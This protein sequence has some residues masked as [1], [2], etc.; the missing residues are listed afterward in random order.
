MIAFFD[1][2]VSSV[3][4]KLRQS[5]HVP[6]Y[7]ANQA[8]H[9]MTRFQ[10]HAFVF[11]LC[12]LATG[13]AEAQPQAQ[14]TTV[15]LNVNGAYQTGSDRFSDTRTFTL[16]GESGQFDVRYDVPRSS[17]L[18]DLSG[19]VMV[20]RN[21]GVGVG[22]SGMSSTS[23]AEVSMTAPHPLFTERS[24]RATASVA[25]L[26][27]SELG[28]HIQAVW[29]T[30]VNDKIQI[31]VSGGPS[32]FKVSQDLVTSLSSAEVGPP[33]DEVAVGGV[34]T[35]SL[36]ATGVGVNAGVDVAW[37]FRRELGAG[38]FA[39]YAG[40]STDFTLDSGTVSVKAGGFQ[41]GIGL[42]VRY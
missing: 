40:A 29:T 33:F 14:D 4:T 12:A 18:G 3:A 21:L 8:F 37:M 5:T 31:A 19:G 36:D 16:Y 34:T 27:H 11:C 15:F 7:P 20:W 38:F 24:R 23:S 35:A 17:V 32:I 1:A 41:T 10:R 25:P 26:D 28:V 2:A 13:S 22:V 39:R 30:V 42:R 6:P 9:T